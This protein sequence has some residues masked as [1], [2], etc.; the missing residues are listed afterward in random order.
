[1]LSINFAKAFDSAAW[2]AVRDGARAAL[3]QR[4]ALCVA[5]A[6]SALLC[7][8]CAT[9]LPTLGPACPV[10]ALPAASRSPC[11]ACLAH[12]P[13]FTATIAAFTY[14]FPVDR[15]LRELKYGSR[16]ALADW[17]GSALGAAV[18]R[19]LDARRLQER[20][21]CVVALP[22]G[23]DRQR[24]RGFNQAQ[25]IAV[26]V[27]GRLGLPMTRALTRTAETA[28]QSKLSWSE[29][30]ANIR[31]AFAASP[32]IRG[33]HPA[34]VDDVMTTGATLAEAARTLLRGGAQRV[35]CWVVAR[36]LREGGT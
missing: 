17:A 30:A 36:T 18:E 34:V 6:G 23:R 16:L 3:P 8:A 20:P 26:R 1:M 10:C 28:P 4:C 2:R 14:A 21:D 7:D 32:Q 29:R 33:L 12:A 19:A 15:L 27:A 24:E 25:E 5:D 31:G 22:L 13:P 11:G 35:E 9:A